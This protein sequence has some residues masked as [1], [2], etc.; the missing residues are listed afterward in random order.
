M[1]KHQKKG[2]DKWNLTITIPIFKT[3]TLKDE[4]E[5]KFWVDE[6]K[7]FQNVIKEKYE[8]AKV[9]DKIKGPNFLMHFAYKY[10]D[11]NWM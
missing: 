6:G 11:D 7:E 8:R 9:A 4:Q 1:Q 3:L 2:K 5:I 10:W